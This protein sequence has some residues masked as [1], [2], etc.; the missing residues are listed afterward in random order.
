MVNEQDCNSLVLTSL[1]SKDFPSIANSISINCRK[2]NIQVNF[3]EE[4]NDYWCRD[5]MPLQVTKDRFVQFTFNP[6]YYK[7]PKYHH[8]KT[9]PANLNFDLPGVVKSEIVCDGG[10]IAYYG[11]KAIVTGRIF[12][13]NRGLKKEFIIEEMTRLLELESLYVIPSLPYDVTGHAD[14]MVRFIDQHTLFINDARLFTGI[15]YWNKLLKS[16]ESF[17]LV[18]LLND[19]HKNDCADD[20]TGDYLNM[21]M[22][23][24]LIFVPEYNNQTDRLAHKLIE[25]VFQKHTIIPV[26]A[27]RLASKCGILHCASWNLLQ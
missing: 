25:K 20:A 13:D 26:K 5:F 24:N 19:L 4:C 15:N 3:L 7:S 23:G 8:L 12:K 21:I 14:G 2:E 9:D 22:I 17:N 27:N 6:A 18:L 16:L 10:N 11:S 1:L